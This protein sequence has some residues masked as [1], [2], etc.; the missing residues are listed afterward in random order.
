MNIFIIS[1]GRTATTTLASAF[2]ALDG[3][4]SGHETQTS[5][6]G[7]DRITF[8]AN[9]VECDNRL[10]WFLP[11]LTRRYSHNSLLI[12]VNRCNEE[13]SRSYDKRWGKINIMKA[14]SQ[15]ILLR[16]LEDNSIE[17]CRDYV[18]NC[19]EHLAFFSSHWRYHLTLELDRP[20]AA[21]AEACRLADRVHSTPD[22]L[23][24]L[25]GTVSNKNR[26]GWRRK[27][28]AA[29]FNLRALVW[30]IRNA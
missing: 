29:Y 8:P 12:T 11:R 10:I 20:D 17:V 30:D 3:Y 15:G 4:T 24:T 16:S 2:G 7:A 26:P 21:I 27:I 18:S 19:Y 13:I 28:D 5:Y 23:S 1:P 25:Y 6:L 14:Y 9:H 22:V